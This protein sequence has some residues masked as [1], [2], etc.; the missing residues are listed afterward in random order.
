M[1]RRRRRRGSAAEPMARGEPEPMPLPLGLT[2]EAIEVGGE[3]LVVFAFPDRRAPPSSLTE[4]ENAVVDLILQGFTTAQIA[5]AR[6][7]TRATI[8]SQ[9]QSIYRKLGVTSRAELACKLDSAT[10]QR[11]AL[12][13]RRCRQN[14]DGGATALHGIHG[15]E[16]CEA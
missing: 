7:V 15:P 5:A 12:V 13:D 10:D 8:S 4:A 1:S 16:G 9:L 3:T 11:R 14:D 2:I 6:G